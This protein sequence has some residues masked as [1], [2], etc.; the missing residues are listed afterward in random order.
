LWLEKEKSASYFGRSQ[1]PRHQT[2]GIE[3]QPALIARADRVIE[4]SRLIGVKRTLEMRMLESEKDPA[5]VKTSVSDSQ[6]IYSASLS[7]PATQGGLQGRS[8]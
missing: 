7:T 3:V 6:W 5:C 2:L 8:S 4:Q 1:A